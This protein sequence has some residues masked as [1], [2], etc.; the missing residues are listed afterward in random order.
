M[1]T[2]APILF[3]VVDRDAYVDRP[4][5]QEALLRAV[6]T[7]R[8]TL[9]VGPTGSG[10]TT[11]LNWLRRRLENDR[12]PVA[13]IDA[14][15]VD[16][17]LVFFEI[18]QHAITDARGPGT[19]PSRLTEA[20][21]RTLRIQAAAGELG[22]APATVLLVD[23]LTDSEL[24][25]TLFGRMRDLLW[26][27]GHRWVVTARPADRAAF[28][29]PPADAFF[30][31]RVSVAPLVPEELDRFVALSDL[32]TAEAERRLVGVPP[33][34]REVIHALRREGEQSADAEV[35]ESLGPAVAAVMREVRALDRPVGVDDADLRARTGLSP[36]TLR[37]Y[38]NRL[39]AAGYL[40]TVTDRRSGAPGRPRR[41]FALTGAG[42]SE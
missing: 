41:L 2:D 37:K 22:A 12:T 11:L 7:S 17:P 23:N 32:P 6:A 31:A 38:L 5:V 1:L 18:A 14:A 26:E 21:S 24:A 19:S 8:G 25:R 30:S 3:D 4:S 40:E 35:N 13:R 29:A 20:A 27:S 9:L 16:D 15:L 34:P 36:I 33:Q 28:L 10:R 39:A 42:M